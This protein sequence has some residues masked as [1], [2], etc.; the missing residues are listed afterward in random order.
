MEENH[1]I[2]Y[3]FWLLSPMLSAPFII[4]IVSCR[5]GRLRCP[6]TPTYQSTTT[7]RLQLCERY[8]AST[9]MS[10]SYVYRWRRM[11]ECYASIF[12]LRS[13]FVCDLHF[14]PVCLSFRS[15]WLPGIGI[16]LGMRFCPRADCIEYNAVES[17]IG[18]WAAVFGLPPAFTVYSKICIE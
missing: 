15:W 13:I 1:K 2:N 18:S 3:R 11:N 7:S 5:G 8:R 17:I 9:S 16:E 4:V 14:C 12:P 10:N 6:T